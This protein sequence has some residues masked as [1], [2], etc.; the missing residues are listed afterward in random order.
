M[1][2]NNVYRV[3]VKDYCSKELL[4]KDYENDFKKNGYKKLPRRVRSA[5]LD[6]WNNGYLSITIED[7]V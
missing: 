2:K 7:K 1:V 3:R 4:F 6:Y 5:L